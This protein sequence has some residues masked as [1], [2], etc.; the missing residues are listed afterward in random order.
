MTLLLKLPRW[1]L[2]TLCTAAILYIT[3]AP[4]P[5]GAEMLPTF[6]GYDKVIHGIM[7]GGLALCAAID[8]IYHQK[9]APTRSAWLLIGA[10]CIVF[11]GVDE[12]LQSLLTAERAASWGDWLADIAGTALCLTACP[13]IW[14]RRP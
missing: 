3:L 6:P 4:Q 8:G 13:Y 14:P 2:T 11:G 9:T 1:L 12:L 7:F 5:A 10:A